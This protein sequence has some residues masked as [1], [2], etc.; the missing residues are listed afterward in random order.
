M[1]KAISH[2]T[3][4]LVAAVLLVMVVVGCSSSKIVEAPI[5]KVETSTATADT[6]AGTNTAPKSE[7][8]M[9][10][11]H[12]LDDPK[13][14]LANRSIYF[15]VDSAQVSASSIQLLT[16]HGKYLRAHGMARIRLEGHADERGGREYNLALGQ[17]RAEAVGKALHW[18]A[19]ASPK[20]KPSVTVKR[21][22][23]R[24][25]MTKPHGP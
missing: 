23:L 2:F 9:V 17:K 20:W 15:E 7:V 12:P 6:K 1:Y 5:V 13:S 4:L 11:L 8:K 14:P 19:L 24:V 18:Q 10:V 3:T 21:S 22:P 25:A 16:E